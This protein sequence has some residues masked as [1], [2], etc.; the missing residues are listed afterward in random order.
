[1][2]ERV[3]QGDLF[4]SK[5]QTL[6]NTVNTV[7]IMGK[8]VALEF[9]KRFPDMFR[10]YELR[11]AAKEVRLG[12]P[13]LFRRLLTPWIIN[14]PTKEHWRAVSRLD[15]I[16]RGLEY[17]EAHVGEWEVESLAVPP[18]G[19]GNGQLDW[20]I[21]GPTLYRHLDRLPI[22][23]ELYAPHN[24]SAGSLS[25]RFLAGNADGLV[26]EDGPRLATTDLALAE[27]V[28]RLSHER[29]TWP[30][31]H[32]RFQK[33]CYFAHA[34]GIPLEVEF[35]ERSYGPFA[36]GLKRVLARMVNNGVLRER[37]FRNYQL[38]EPGPTFGDAEHRFASAVEQYQHQI[39]RVTDLMLRLSPRRTEL[40]ATVH[41]T[42]RALRARLG[43]APTDA[44]VLAEAK[45]WKKSRFAETEITD[46]LHDLAM[47][48]WLEL[49]DTRLI[50]TRD[51]V[52][53]FA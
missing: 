33:L 8:G 17:L 48:G 52:S 32:T 22:P 39:D 15:A 5:A 28:A 19:C 45:R 18:L 9:K 31:G 34:S 53:A 29:Y 41:F 26:V 16:V 4:E 7:G 44:E 47:M 46:A 25:Q 23:V 10:D 43:R 42:A 14:F 27:V 3:V 20:D 50:D 1:M 51:D 21:V 6:V 38:V 49:G 37:S 36:T 35:M 30:V 12:E 24:A 40:A 11:C 13:Y 2:I